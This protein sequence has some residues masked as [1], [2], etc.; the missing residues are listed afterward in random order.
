MKADDIRESFLKFFESKGHRVAPSDSLVPADDPTLLFTGAGMNQFK[1]QFL[2]KGKMDY[3]RAVSCQKCLRTPDIEKVGK[4]SKHHTFFEMLGNFSFGDYFKKEAIEW[5]WEYLLEVMKLPE[6]QLL[7][8][9]YEDDEEAYE[10]WNK[11]IGVPDDRIYRFGEDE[12]FWPARAPSEGP[13]G[14]CGPCS[15]IFYDRGEKVGCGQPDCNPSCDCDRFVELWNLVFTQFDRRDGGVLKPLPHKNIDTGMGLERMAAVMQNVVSNFDTDLFMPI[16]DGISEVTETAY[17]SQSENGARMRRIADHIRA[18]A[19]C[20]SDGVLPSNEGRGYVLRRLVRRAIVDGRNIGCN[21]SF[22]YKIVPVIADVMKKPY[23]ELLERRENIARIIQNEEARFHQTLDQGSALLDRMIKTMQ[24]EKAARLSGALAFK[25]YDTYGFPVEMTHAILSERGLSVNM[26]EFKDEMEK[27]R[28]LA[29]GGSAIS[30]DIFVIGPL[31]HLKKTIPK[32][33]FLGYEMTEA[34]ATVAG[35]IK[36]PEILETADSRTKKE[37]TLI[38]DRTPFYGE[39]GGQVGDTGNIE[40]E[41]LLFEVTDSKR[42]DDYT[43]HIGKIIKG[44]VKVGDAVKASVNKLDRKKTAANHTATHLLNYAL[45]KALGKHVTQAGSLVAPDRLRFDF[46]HFEATTPEQLERVEEMVNAEI[47]ESRPVRVYTTSL[48]DARSKGVITI[49]GEKYSDVVRVVE[50]V[51]LSKELCGGTHLRNIGDIRIFKIVNEESVAA[52]VR[53]ITAL[54]G[55]AALKEITRREGILKDLSR[56]LRAAPEEL[57]KRIRAMQQEIKKLK[58]D[59]QAARHGGSKNVIEEILNKAL[60][61][62]ETKIAA[63]VIEDFTPDDLRRTLD[64]IKAKEESVAVILASR[65]DTKVHLILGFSKDLVEKGLNA[66]T[67]IKEVAKIVGG[68]G[69][70]RPDMA[71][72]GGSKPDKLEEAVQAGVKKISEKLSS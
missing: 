72:A 71:Q 41:K 13:N 1:E 56:L 25:L 68:G 49:P 4:T 59:L 47:A 62:G 37:L 34:E 18:V 7:V 6:E 14:V 19:F 27:Q 22:L 33:E 51:G 26:Q 67:L 11:G 32:T 28:E 31:A 65:T 60:V 70:G 63:G 21:E 9:I 48:E 36:G 50:T 55:D 24:K 54:T 64:T 42:S 30:S 20:I 10:I 69:G 39:A 16:I 15:E 5:A 53:R 23:P 43:L 3:R 61:K 58:K 57:E 29:R 17:E 52:G 44:A 2:G 35:I 8:S 45:R 46:T 40:S 66:G 38:L 12:N